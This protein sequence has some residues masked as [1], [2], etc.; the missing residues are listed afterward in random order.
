METATRYLEKKE[1][2]CSKIYIVF[3][4][5]IVQTSK[6]IYETTVRRLGHGP[7]DSD[8]EKPNRKLTLR[9]S[10]LQID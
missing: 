8:I 3:I 5:H 6:T 1:I 9:C 4:P 10:N 2:A 7:D